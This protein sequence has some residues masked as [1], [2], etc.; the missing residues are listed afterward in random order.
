MM[1]FVPEQRKFPFSNQLSVKKKKKKTTA[2][3]NRI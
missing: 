2:T 3:C 1:I